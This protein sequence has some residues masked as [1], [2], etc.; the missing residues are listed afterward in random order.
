MLLMPINLD[1]N[2]MVTVRG[3]KV[4]FFQNHCRKFHAYLVTDDNADKHNFISNI[5]SVLH[6]E[7]FHQSSN[8]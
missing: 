7:Y 6:C 4:F 1:N 3:K 5:L 8:I 2:Q